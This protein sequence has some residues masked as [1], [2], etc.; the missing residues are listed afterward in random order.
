MAQINVTV[1]DADLPD[2]L[3]A[4]AETHGYDPARHGT[5]A[6]FARAVV[7]RYIRAP[8]TPWRHVSDLPGDTAHAS[9]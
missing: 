7:A 8:G 6:T 4:F 1:N 2:V 9:N 5:K 3:N